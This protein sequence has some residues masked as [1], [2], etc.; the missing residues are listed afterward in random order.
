[1]S[2]VEIA[3]GTGVHRSSGFC[4]TVLCEE[5]DIDSQDH[6]SIFGP[7][8]AIKNNSWSFA[9]RKLRLDQAKTSS[10]TPIPWKAVTP[11]RDHY[12]T[13]TRIIPCVIL[14]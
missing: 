9:F 5:C 11:G 3:E 8:R 13:R 7:S 1:M 4:T 6:D 14:S 12:K 10:D 2:S